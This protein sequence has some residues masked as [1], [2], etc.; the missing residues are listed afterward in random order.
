M[1]K[2][3]RFPPGHDDQHLFAVFLSLGIV[4]YMRRELPLVERILLII[5]AF[6][7]VIAPVGWSVPGMTPL[8]AGTLMV[9]Y[10]L[11]VTRNPAPQSEA[12]A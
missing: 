3:A 6:A 9:L 10:H 12:S 5:V 11:R 8:A 7:M 1:R 4:G 2:L